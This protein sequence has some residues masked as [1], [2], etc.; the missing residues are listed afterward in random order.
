[1]TGT[2][3]WP[4]EKQPQKL[5][6]KTWNRCHVPDESGSKSSTLTNVYSSRVEKQHRTRLGFHHS[7]STSKTIRDYNVIH[8]FKAT[9]SSSKL[10]RSSSTDTKVPFVETSS[11]RPR[12]STIHES[13][14]LTM[15]S[16]CHPEYPHMC[17][18]EQAKNADV[19]IDFCQPSCYRGIM[20]K[21][22]FNCSSFVHPYSQDAR[23]FD[24][25]D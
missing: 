12:R 3:G 13:N 23:N 20:L 14:L 2:D 4:S 18:L 5:R 16:I 7:E 25:V 24:Q 8:I 19:K 17:C 22:T 9:A 10:I 21:N 1:M 15:S 6:W 11:F